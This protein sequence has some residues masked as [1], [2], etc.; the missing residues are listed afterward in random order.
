MEDDLDG[1]DAIDIDAGTLND[2]R[3]DTT[4]RKPAVTISPNN[5]VMA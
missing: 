2:A 5:P 3:F 1:D 4:H